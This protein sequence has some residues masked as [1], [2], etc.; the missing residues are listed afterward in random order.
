MY[1][2]VV[3]MFKKIL[4][5]I[6]SLILFMRYKIKYGSNIHLSVINSIRGKFSI[7]IQNNSNIKLGKF[8]MFQGPIYIKANSGSK[9]LIGDNV[10]F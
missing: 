3:N 7:D 10:F 8:L 6:R 9:L 2:C 1:T 5:G 4:L